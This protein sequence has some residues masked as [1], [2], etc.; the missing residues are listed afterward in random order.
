VTHE[1]RTPLT[2]VIG[3]LETLQAG[4]IDNTEDARRFVDIM[5]KQAR[6]LNRLVE[7]L[8]TI[9]KIELGEVKFR[10]EDVA[11]P[12]VIDSVLPL[13]DAKASIK[14]ICIKNHVPEK[15]L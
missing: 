3:Y 10:F 14:K 15:C 9:S 11:L 6:R 4:A 1:I 2:A 13:M 8:M 7:D 5:L 12:E